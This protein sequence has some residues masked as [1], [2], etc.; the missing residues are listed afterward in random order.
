MGA[1]AHYALN[2]WYRFCVE[3]GQNPHRKVRCYKD[4]WERIGTF[5]TAAEFR[6]GFLGFCRSPILL[7]LHVG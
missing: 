5:L 4:G 3:W 2:L 1:V 6:Y 7:V